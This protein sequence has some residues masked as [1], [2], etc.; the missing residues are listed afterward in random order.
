MKIIFKGLYL[1]NYIFF[2]L[3]KIYEAS[4][5]TPAALTT[6][7][8]FDSLTATF[9]SFNNKTAYEKAYNYKI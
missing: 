6:L 8:K 5:L 1:N 2:I 4:A 7:F 9:P 3:I